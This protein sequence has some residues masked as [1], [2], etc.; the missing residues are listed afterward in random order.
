MI[1][2]SKYTVNLSPSRG[3][4]EVSL[5]Q[6]ETGRQIE[7][8]LIDNDAVYIPTGTTVTINGTK[9]DGNVYSAE[10]TVDPDNR[11]ATFDEDDQ[12]T[13]I[14]GKW[15][16]KLK[17]I[18]AG[19]VLFTSR[20]LFA[21][22]ADVVDPNAVPSDSQIDGFIAEARHYAEEAK[23]EAYGSPLVARTASE[24]SDRSRVYVYIGREEGYDPGY[25]YYYNGTSWTLGG[26]YN[27]ID[28]TLE[29][30]GKAADAKATGDALNTKVDK[31]E[32]FG[33][34]SNDFTTAEKEK[35]AAIQ[36]GATRVIIDSVISDTSTNPIQNGIVKA[37]I[38]AGDETDPSLQIPG[39]SADAQVT[40]DRIANAVSEYRGLIET[41]RQARTS[42]VTAEANLRSQGITAE[43][44]ARTSAINQERLA[45]EQAITTEQTAREHAINSERAAREAAIAELQGQIDGHLTCFFYHYNPTTANAPANSWT[46]DAIRNIH[47]GDL[48]YNTSTGHMWRW[49]KNGNGGYLWQR[50]SDTDVTKA[51]SDIRAL[52]E[53][54]EDVNETLELKAD[55]SELPVNVS[56]L[57]NDADYATKEEVNEAVS[58]VIDPTLKVSGKAADA[59][60]TGDAL[61][62][63]VD[64]VAG[65]QLSENN[66]TTYEREKL[67]GISSGA[68]R[69]IVDYQMNES[70][71][72][73]VQS[74][75][76]KKYVDD[77]IAA[78]DSVYAKRE[79]IPESPD[80]T[81]ITTAEIDVMFE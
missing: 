3:S 48:F 49:M 23:S 65:R 7:F 72:N 63:K 42:A 2:K 70:S 26:S 74:R 5:A 79:D 44:N 18:H 32:G 36:Q 38:D 46:T 77:N 55:K 47:L 16:A 9:P 20:L 29:E 40:G 13:A 78:L 21:V 66:Y 14:S 64:K 67:A 28:E 76:I 11:T 27:A 15:P 8:T 54:L 31:A 39:K 57:T 68:T 19:E 80:L 24:M 59:K 69:V 50:V 17:L 30:A 52:Q 41:E 58:I 73:P 33:L 6:Y 22:D 71:S 56:E 10:G 61:N 35:L 12:L 60:A 25:W 43:R 75:I 4:T 62:N 53:S 1:H 51:L 45:R 81:L 34:S 37:Y